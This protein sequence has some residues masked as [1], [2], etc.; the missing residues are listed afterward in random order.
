MLFL[1]I[2]CKDLSLCHESINQPFSDDDIS[3]SFNQWCG[4]EPFLAG[5]GPGLFKSRSRIRLRLYVSG[6]FKSRSRIRLRLYVPGLFKSRNRIRLRIYVSGLFKSRSRIRLRLYLL[7]PTLESC[8]KLRLQ[9][10][11]NCLESHNFGPQRPI[12]D[13]KDQNKPSTLTM[14]TTLYIK[15]LKKKRCLNSKRF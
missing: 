12:L 6:L 7:A 8:C 5:S 2:A 3:F 1:A 9:H 15:F 10:T 14:L 4:E 11:V 13:R